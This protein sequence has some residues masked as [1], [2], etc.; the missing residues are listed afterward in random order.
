MRTRIVTIMRR[1]NEDDDNEKGGGDGDGVGNLMYWIRSR[2][3]L[4]PV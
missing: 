4:L 3:K 2:T 1:R